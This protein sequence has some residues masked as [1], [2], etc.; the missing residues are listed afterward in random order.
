MS[1]S[2]DA[3]VDLDHPEAYAPSRKHR[4]RSAS[5]KLGRSGASSDSER[6]QANSDGE[7]NDLPPELSKSDFLLRS[8]SDFMSSSMEDLS[9]SPKKKKKK[10][11][12][13]VRYPKA[14]QSHSVHFVIWFAVHVA[15][16]LVGKLATVHKLLVG[17]FV[18]WI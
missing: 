14:N 1:S 16:C 4:S 15:G 7:D 13:Y 18:P 6:R 17:N 9:G 3:L 8:D 10:R 11:V 2:V 5:Q 12:K